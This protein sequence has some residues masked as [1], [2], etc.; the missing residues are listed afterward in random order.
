MSETEKIIRFL[1]E[2][3]G[4]GDAPLRTDCTD[5][6]PESFGLYPKGQEVYKRREDVT[7]TVTI[8]CRS[9]YLL[10]RM[11]KCREEENARW[12]Q[13]LTDWV[14]Q[15]SAMRRVPALGDGYT[16]LRAENGKL[17]SRD[18]AGT[19]VYE[20]DLIAEYEMIYKGE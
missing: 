17:K 1:R 4:W 6:A 8:S 9:R 14:Q 7:G 2:F 18:Q 13:A 16:R 20:L 11:A 10:R 5:A 3:P 19:A 12:L 15:E